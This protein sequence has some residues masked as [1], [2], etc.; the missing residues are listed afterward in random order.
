MPEPGVALLQTVAALLAGYAL[1]RFW[2]AIA[3]RGVG[4]A[5]IAIG[6]AL[7]AMGGAALFVVSWLELP[8]ARSLQLGNGLWFFALDAR[9]Y[10]RKADIWILGGFQDVVLP[11]RS[12]ASY[13]Y[14]QLVAVCRSLFGAVH[15]SSLL[16]N[17]FAY[18]GVALV[19]ATWAAAGDARRNRIGVAVLAALAL[20]PSWV[21]WSLQPLKDA[22]FIAAA[23]A[24][25]AASDRWYQLWISGAPRVSSLLAVAACCWFALHVVGGIRWYYACLAWL[26]W[27]AA[28]AFSGLA[29]R[30]QRAQFWLASILVFGLLAQAVAL[31]L[32]YGLGES[33]LRLLEVP[34]WLSAEVDDSRARFASEY[35]AS[36]RIEAGPVFDGARYGDV[37]ARASMVVLP[38]FLATPL[39]L[40]KAGGGRGLWLFAEADTIAFDAVVLF[41]VV[42]GWRA[43]SRRLVF[44][45]TFVLAI[46]LIAATLPM[47]WAVNNFGT[48]LRFREMFMIPL[49]VI[50]LVA[51]RYGEG[52]AEG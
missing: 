14:V 47:L 43:R 8:F 28:M 4:V 1:F 16:I 30:E 40:A 5:V 2:R 9:A 15:S 18:L 36:T 21:L 26:L 51:A 22:L 52:R 37:A 19:I 49:L 6:F 50:P 12:V 27:F 34:T 10:A 46:A 48:L 45:G 38:R 42:V 35:K 29:L 11:D 23:V 39:G 17:L 31:N 13:V 41:A 33:N 44:D 20:M 3:A 32:P 7:R 25:L 24:F